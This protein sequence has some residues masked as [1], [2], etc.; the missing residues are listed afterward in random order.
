MIINKIVI[1]D[2]IITVFHH[3]SM[4]Q[5]KPKFGD[6]GP[7]LFFLIENPANST[8]SDRCVVVNTPRDLR[9]DNHFEIKPPMLYWPW[10]F[11]FQSSLRL[12]KNRKVWIITVTVNMPRTLF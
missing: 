5:N 11:L 6:F 2:F 4:V 9:N 3:F 12:Y 1:S 10:L 7:V 8:Y